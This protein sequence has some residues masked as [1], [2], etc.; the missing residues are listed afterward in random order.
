MDLLREL[1]PF[2]VG[3]VIPPIIVSMRVTLDGFIAGPHG[4]MDWMEEF[5]DEALANYESELQK[6]VD[7]TLFGRVTYEGF[8][9]YWPKIPEGPASPQGMVEYAHQLNAMRK[10]VFS[11]TLSRVEWNNSTLVKEIVPEEIIKMKQEPGRDMVIY[12]SAKPLFQDILHKVK[13]SLVSTKRH[14][15]GVVELTY[16]PIKG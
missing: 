4:E 14:P 9:S 6:M 5:L 11:R 12:G 13:L 10:I 8:E 1:V 15:S 2:L 7:T 3:M 16:Q